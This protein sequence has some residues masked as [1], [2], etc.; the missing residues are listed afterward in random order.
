MKQIFQNLKSGSTEV[1]NIPI[2]KVAPGHILIQSQRTLVSAGTERMLVEFGKAGYLKKARQQP[3][4]VKMIFDKIKTDGLQ[5][6]LEA[7]F[8]KLDEPLPLGYC[9]AGIVSEIGEGVTGFNVG[10]RVI[11]NGKH[12]EFVIAP[13]NLVAKIPDGVT[14]DVAAFTVAGAISLQGL[15]LANPTLGETVAVIGLGLIGQLTIQLLMANGCQV[16]GMDFDSH[17]LSLAAKMGAKVVDLSNVKDVVSATNVFSRGRGID[18]AIITASTKSNDPVSQAAQMCRKRGRIILVGT[19]GLQLSRADFYE[20]ELTFQVSCSYGPGRYDLNYEEKGN[21]YPIGFV[22]WTEQRNFEAILDMMVNER[23][24][25]ESLISHQFDIDDAKSAYGLML[26]DKA[27]LGILLKY[28]Q[29]SETIADLRKIEASNIKR[30]E[31]ALIEGQVNLGFIGAGQYAKS[32]LIP[33]F[34]KTGV[35][36][37]SIASINGVSG[38][39]ATQK[40]GFLEN[41][42]DS[43]IVIENPHHNAIVIAT[44][45]D[46]HAELVMSALKANKHVFVEKPLCL[47]LT[48]IDK[49]KAAYQKPR[50]KH[51]ASNFP[52]LMVGFNRRFAPHIIKIK[53]ILKS[54][55]EPKCFVMNV[56]AGFIPPDHWVHDR[57]IGGGRII[58]EV[59]HFID[60]LRFLAESPITGWQRLTMKSEM[61]DTVSIQL[62]FADGSIGSIN[63]FANGNK[64]LVKER[65]EVFAEG[66]VLQLDNF[67]K[68][69]GFGWKNF[70]KM[71][72]WK[73]DKGQQACVTA[74]VDAI[75]S[76]GKSPIP[77]EEIIEV[78]QISI[79]LAS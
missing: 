36:L 7:V 61:D 49:I 44:R 37:S 28:P 72:L 64:S 6:T 29:I 8:N 77:F 40:F 22:R 12:A 76:G 75:Q 2:P 19:S 9:N 48:D 43:Q 26:S 79:E 30:P 46:S 60:L 56:N 35:R 73:Q 11:S 53:D 5:P 71:R 17:R 70:D 21:D 62:A 10:D 1:L 14:D 55:S 66:G 34:K 32:T 52:I 69:T 24:N 50:S 33:A 13:I 57:Q 16:I 51:L 78:S 39:K 20:K 27:S 74:F 31:I 58:G 47:S 18:A 41:V 4:K 67:R 65:L 38:L 42:T 68:L 45:H 54:V 25:L 15:R 59:C 3:D 63:Y 23:L